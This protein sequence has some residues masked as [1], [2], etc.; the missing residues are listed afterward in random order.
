MGT[1]RDAFHSR[2]GSSMVVGKEMGTLLLLQRSRGGT[3]MLVGRFFLYS[4]GLLSGKPH[5]HVCCGVRQAMAS[6]IN[7]KVR[8]VLS[9]LR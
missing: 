5:P 6:Y 7:S 3:Q 8:S 9:V 2:L 4:F 1:G